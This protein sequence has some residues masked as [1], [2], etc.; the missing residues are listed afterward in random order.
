MLFRANIY[1]ARAVKSPWPNREWAE[2]EQW[3]Q[4]AITEAEKTGNVV[5]AA[6]SKANLGLA[7]Q[8]KGDLDAALLLFEAAWRTVDTLQAPYLQTQIDL[9]LTWLH[10]QR[11]ERVAAEETLHR[12]KERMQD[13][14]YRRLK[15]L[16]EQLEQMLKNA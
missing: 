14:N 10:L 11:G 2:A 8:G 4:R 16:A 7:A 13:K 3:F 9:W 15:S 1:I 6:N 12:A 5:Q